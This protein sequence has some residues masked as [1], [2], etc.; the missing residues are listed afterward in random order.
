MSR[1]SFKNTLRA[2]LRSRRV[3]RRT[4]VTGGGVSYRVDRA[5]AQ[6]AALVNSKIPVVVIRPPV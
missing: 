5:N 4:E 6:T 3:G 1:P 2:D